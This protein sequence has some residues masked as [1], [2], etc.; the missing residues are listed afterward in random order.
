L[1]HRQSFGFLGAPPQTLSRR[2]L[3]CNLYADSMSQFQ[4]E[5]PDSYTITSHVLSVSAGVI[6]ETPTLEGADNA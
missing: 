5:V 6:L 1:D 4:R 3:P 2:R